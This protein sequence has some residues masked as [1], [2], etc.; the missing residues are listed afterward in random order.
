MTI[1]LQGC[2]TYLFSGLLKVKFTEIINQM[3]LCNQEYNEC[4]KTNLLSCL[5]DC[6]IN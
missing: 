4:M 1:L 6:I 2:V 5:Y 3:T